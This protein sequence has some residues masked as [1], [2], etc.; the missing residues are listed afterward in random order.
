MS[1]GNKP[2]NVGVVRGGDGATTETSGGDGRP[3]S[4]K[5]ARGFGKIWS[6]RPDSIGSRRVK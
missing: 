5:A 1:E 2:E 3:S 6:N 4:A